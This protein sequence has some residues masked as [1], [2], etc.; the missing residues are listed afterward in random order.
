MGILFR[1]RVKILRGVNLNISKS[2]TSL[3]V[4]PRGAKVT[5]GKRG[6]YANVGIPGTGIYTRKK[7][8]NTNNSNRKKYNKKNRDAEII[9]DNPL[10]FIVIYV[11]VFLSFILPLT[12]SISWWL[13]PI[14]SIGGIILGICIPNPKSNITAINDNLS[15]NDAK[16]SKVE[17]DKDFSEIIKKLQLLNFDPYFLDAA[18][19]VI[20][21][22]ECS[23]SKIREN[24]SIEYS[25]AFKIVEQLESVGIVGN[26]TNIAPRKVLLSN[27]R[28]LFILLKDINVI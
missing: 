17:V 22:K 7:I 27:D 9:N 26:S 1:K 3:S 25:R 4:G 18:R 12:T 28:D 14:L 19:L 6:V 10:R 8:A 2:G 5:I 23:I 20:S 11:S 16:I 24:F 21:L 13:F 15:D